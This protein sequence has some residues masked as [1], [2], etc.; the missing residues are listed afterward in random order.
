MVVG[1]GLTTS[2]EKKRCKR[3]MRKKKRYTH[4]NAEFQ[5][6]ARKGKE[7]FLSVFGKEFSFRMMKMFWK[8]IIVMVAQQ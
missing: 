1:G 5:R 6:I 3:Q 8:W 4:M 2:R 7:T